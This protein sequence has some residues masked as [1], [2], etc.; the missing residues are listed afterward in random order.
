[1]RVRYTL[2]CCRPGRGWA[3]VAVRLPSP[4]HGTLARPPSRRLLPAARRARDAR[5]TVC[6]S[7]R[8]FQCV[9]IIDRA[10][11]YELK[12]KRFC[13]DI[14]K[15]GILL[16]LGVI[17]DDDVRL[18]LFDGTCSTFFLFFFTEV[19]TACA[20]VLLW[21]PVACV[22]DNV[23]KCFLRVALWHSA[24]TRNCAVCYINSAM[25]LFCNKRTSC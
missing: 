20:S 15:V 14:A 7:I 3:T 12:V 21:R 4:L 5:R 13:W 24:K 18:K 10:Q 22:C 1:M 2:N 25:Q 17:M 8:R 19:F 6:V 16:S 11:T 23:P 9:K